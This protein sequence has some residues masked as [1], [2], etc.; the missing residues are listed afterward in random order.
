M[1]SLAFVACD[2][3]P[4]A[5]SGPG[6]LVGVLRSPSGPEGAAVID[7]VGTGLGELTAKS[8]LVFTEATDDVLRVIIVLEQPGTIEFVLEVDDIAAPPI[9]AVLEVA[10]PDDR[11][12]TTLTE[13]SVQFEPLGDSR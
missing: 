6:R 4:A 11:P 5:V 12:R 3:Q 1:V 2:S 7:L 8:G 10:D 9:A 13:Y